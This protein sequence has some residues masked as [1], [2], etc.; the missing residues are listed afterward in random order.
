MAIGFFEIQSFLSALSTFI[1]KCCLCWI[2]FVDCSISTENETF[3]EPVCWYFYNNNNT[4]TFLQCFWEGLYSCIACQ[5]NVLT[6]YGWIWI[7]TATFSVQQPQS[8]GRA[9]IHHS[10][11]SS[12]LSV[13]STIWV[14]FVAPMVSL[15]DLLISQFAV[16]FANYS[17]PVK[18]I[19]L[20]SLFILI[21]RNL[22][23]R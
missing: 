6:G 8:S 13:S 11:H 22:D 17:S 1:K 23:H 16:L 18:R 5:F 20:C 14:C 9:N 2:S 7:P 10:V 21:Y 19:K 15:G 12:F 4:H 3:K